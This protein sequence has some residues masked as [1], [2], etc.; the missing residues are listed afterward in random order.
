MWLLYFVEIGTY[1]QPMLTLMA[2]LCKIYDPYRKEIPQGIATIYIT[3][4]YH[5][6]VWVSFPRFPQDP[7]F[8][9]APEINSLDQNVN[10]DM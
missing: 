5:T 1:V 7:L 9:R 8:T 4:L 2:M 3:H 6:S 10:A